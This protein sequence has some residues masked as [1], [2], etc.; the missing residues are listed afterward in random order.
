LAN[1]K[2]F[3]V[4]FTDTQKQKKKIKIWVIIK[5]PS[6]GCFKSHF[7]GQ[8]LIA[9]K[10]LDFKTTANGIME[11]CQS[12]AYSKPY[13]VHFTDTQKQKKKKSKFG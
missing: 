11:L 4:H 7:H 10:I 2:P 13:P 9:T 3:P 1:S 12:L 6:Y 8:I 5:Y